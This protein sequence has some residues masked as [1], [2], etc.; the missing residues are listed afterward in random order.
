MSTS[1]GVNLVQRTNLSLVHA[2]GLVVVL[3]GLYYLLTLPLFGLF[4]IFVGTLIFYGLHVEN[5]SSRTRMEQRQHQE[6][7][8]REREKEREESIKREKAIQ[9]QKKKERYE[10]IKEE[11]ARIFDNIQRGK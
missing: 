10:N 8:K 9:E 5:V 6:N 2:V 3:I 1:E 7:I 4:V 11:A